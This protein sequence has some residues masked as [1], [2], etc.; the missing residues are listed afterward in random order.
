MFAYGRHVNLVLASNVCLI[1]F[2]LHARPQLYVRHG[3]ARSNNASTKRGSVVML[4]LSPTFMFL[5][6]IVHFL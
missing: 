6:W 5:D 4:R 2:H 1:D 3:Y